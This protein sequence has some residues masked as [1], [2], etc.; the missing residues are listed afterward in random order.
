MADVLSINDIRYFN[1]YDNQTKQLKYSKKNFNFDLYKKDFNLNN[2]T[3]LEIFD[4]F[5]VANNTAY[6]NEPSFPNKGTSTPSYLKPTTLKEE[7]KKYFTP[8]T[9]QIINFNNL[10][11]FTV[12]PGYMNIQDPPTYVSITRLVKEQFDLV[13]Y[14]P[15]QLRKLQDY[16]YS[17]K[18]GYYT[19][20]NF[21]FDK[22]SQDFNVYGNK[23]VVFTDFISRVIYSSGSLIGSYGYGI[24]YGFRKYFIQSKNLVDYMNKH[25]TTSIYKNVAFKNEYS[26][27]Y[28]DYAKQV[29]LGNV[30]LE[31]AKENYMRN[32]QFTQTKIKFIIEPLSTKE[33]N[34]SS[35]CTIYTEQGVGSGFLYKNNNDNN[36][37]VVT[38]SHIFNRRNLTTFYAS[39][40][41]NDNT[42]RNIS[43]KAL[44]RVMG[45][46]F[47]TDV[48]LGIYDPELP[49]NKTFKPNLSPYRKLNINLSPKYKI[50][51]NVY[52]FG[53]I[54]DIDDNSFLKGTIM[55]PKFKGSSI[56]NSTYIPE[57]L[58]I[59]MPSENGISGS[60]IFKENN[61]SEVIGL[62]LGVT[63]NEKYV[64]VLTGFILINVIKNII[65]RYKSFSIIYKNNPINF[66]IY[67]GRAVT[68]RWFG[69]QLLL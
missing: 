37:Y 28:Q 17:D 21:N 30:S 60:P 20:Y 6:F 54:G 42:E 40:S 48:C 18:Q 14:K 31:V 9:E 16:F 7:L 32:G 61:D 69:N 68:R 52:T 51:E 63:L 29:N 13:Y 36:I 3:K 35:I 34:L 57:S 67:S 45:R 62:I 49:Y 47:F 11:G 55:N 41:L 26:I 66:Q 5:L 43:T 58:L 46:D 4:H 25:G 8:I 44:F 56:K 1:V 2:K 19:K 33:L 39:F 23:L 38:C 10:Y 27:D 65:D 53:N 50:G 64:I 15:D 59:D 24:P 12:H 22:F